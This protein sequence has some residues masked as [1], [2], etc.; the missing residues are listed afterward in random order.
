VTRAEWDVLAPRERD[1][2]VAEKVM[3]WEK[4]RQFLSEHNF[5]KDL[6]DRGDW[7][8]SDP[9]QWKTHHHIV[10]DHNPWYEDDVFEPGFSPTSSWDAMREVV[11]KTLDWRLTMDGGEYAGD[12]W[13]VT[14]IGNDYDVYASAPTLPEAVCIAA[15]T[16]LGHIHD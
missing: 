5:G 2:L 11:E 6:P 12:R 9:G 8:W 4:R 10:E 14:M 16:A 15:L 3:G 7:V 1:A 13:N